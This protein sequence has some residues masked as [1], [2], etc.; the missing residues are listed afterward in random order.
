M[1]S[2]N[3]SHFLIYLIIV[4]LFV[5]YDRHQEVDRLY[6]I[7]AN[8][9]EALLKFKDAIVSQQNYIKLL[10]VEYI[11]NSQSPSPIH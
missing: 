1:S 10:E 6:K 3:L 8:Q 4:L 7:S 5:L 9:D 2:H 11:K